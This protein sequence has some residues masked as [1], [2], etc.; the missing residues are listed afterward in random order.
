MAQAIILSS[1]LVLST[2]PAPGAKAPGAHAQSHSPGGLL[3]P[4]AHGWSNGNQQHTQPHGP[5]QQLLL[6]STLEPRANSG[7][8]ALSIAWAEKATN[9]PL[10]R[11]LQNNSLRNTPSACATAPGEPLKPLPGGG[12]VGRRQTLLL[13]PHGPLLRWVPGGFPPT[14]PG[15]QEPQPST[16]ACSETGGQGAGPT[17]PTENCGKKPNP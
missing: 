17:K 10:P 2:P 1:C 6:E 11:S 8:Q 9:L 7:S 4:H 5:S 16:E 12:E 15:A 14:L 13:G 3:V